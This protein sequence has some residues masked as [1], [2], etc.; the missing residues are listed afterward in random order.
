MKKE[1]RKL[2]LKRETLITMQ[3]TE[4]DAVH[5]GNIIAQSSDVCANVAG[6]FVAGTFQVVTEL[7]KTRRTCDPKP[8]GPGPAPDKTKG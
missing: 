3:D 4:L 5:G 7:M 1:S 6:T 2:D 8:G